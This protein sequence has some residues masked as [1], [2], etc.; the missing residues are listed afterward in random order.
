M[1]KGEQKGSRNLKTRFLGGENLCFSWFL[2]PLVVAIDL[3]WMIFGHFLG[4]F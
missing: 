2:G 3:F 4:V 1:Q